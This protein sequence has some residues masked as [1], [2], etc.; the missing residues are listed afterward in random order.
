MSPV[1]NCFG[2]SYRQNI[3]IISVILGPIGNISVEQISIPGD[4]STLGGQGT[5]I[6]L[7]LFSSSAERSGGY[8]IMVQG[9]TVATISIYVTCWN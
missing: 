9:I 4:L 7:T 1:I 3:S 5:C 6:I 8:N 2:S